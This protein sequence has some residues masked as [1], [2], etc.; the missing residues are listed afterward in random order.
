[1]QAINSSIAAVALTHRTPRGPNSTVR[2]SL[3][4]KHA[5][6][7]APT[8]QSRIT[9]PANTQTHPRNRSGEN[10]DARLASRKRTQAEDN[11]RALPSYSRLLQ[12]EP[13]DS[14]L[15]AFGGVGL[16]RAARYWR[17]QPCAIRHPGL[18]SLLTTWIGQ[19]ELAH[20]ARL[21]GNMIKELATR[22]YDRLSIP[23][24]QRVKLS[25]GWLDRFKSRQG[26]SQRLFHGVTGSI[27]E[28]LVGP[29]RDRLAA[30]IAAFLAEDE[31]RSL[32]DVWN[33][34][35]NSFFYAATPE[36]GLAQTA[37]PGVRQSRTRLTLLLAV[38]ASGT[39]RMLPL[40][41]GK[42][43]M[44]RCFLKKTAHEH[45]FTYI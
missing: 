14:Q 28:E 38:N 36:K 37:R 5:P 9:R 4:L 12:P 2:I 32:S 8:R 40:F 41:V 6:N 31:S 34:N 19:V 21:T 17:A 20:S 30:V 22:F 18:E 29:E 44:P 35:E 42:Y 27:D 1:M 33:A 3:S 43:R 24:E 39:K 23:E 26:L 11:T 16:A 13:V 25:N 7:Q 15:M 45:G 10:R